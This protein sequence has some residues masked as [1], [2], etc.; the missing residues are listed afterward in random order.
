MISCIIVPSN[1]PYKLDLTQ[2]SASIFFSEALPVTYQSN[3]SDWTHGHSMKAGSSIPKARIVVGQSSLI[4]YFSESSAVWYKAY[5]YFDV[6]FQRHATT[7]TGDEYP[8][9]FRTLISVS[10][11]FTYNQSFGTDEPGIA[12]RSSRSCMETCGGH[13]KLDSSKLM[14]NVCGP[15]TSFLLEDS[16]IFH[17]ACLSQMTV[18]MVTCAELAADFKTVEDIQRLYWQLEKSAMLTTL[19]LPW[20]PGLAKKRMERVTRPYFQ[21]C[22]TTLS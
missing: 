12:V 3:P 18:R 4:P 17:I 8:S 10:F 9:L 11:M 6:D 20:F 15:C 2:R 16:N 5:D 22:I 13:R 21:S 19:L 7:Y 14:Y 1:L